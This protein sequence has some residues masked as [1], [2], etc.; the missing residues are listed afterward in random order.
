LS[1]KFTL[2]LAGLLGASAVAAGAFGAH[3][4]QSM[5]TESALGWYQTASTYHMRH[6]LALLALGLLI[7]RWGS[8]ALATA[9]VWCFSCGTLVFSGSLYIM[10]F[11][12]ITRLGLLT[13][14]GGL[15]LIGGCSCSRLVA[16]QR[17]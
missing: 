16:Q 2:I 4:L 6:A 11:T 17:S 1:A 5:L 15:L 14:I 10:S 12:G 7:E 13:P 8:S 9:A 3:A